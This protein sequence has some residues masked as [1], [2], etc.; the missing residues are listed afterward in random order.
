MSTLVANGFRSLETAPAIKALSHAMTH[1]HE[2]VLL[3]LEENLAQPGRAGTEG[4]RI[5]ACLRAMTSAPILAILPH[6]DEPAQAAV[7]DAGAND[8]V[9]R[10]FD[11][12]N[13]LAR[14]RVWLRQVAR[15]KS[16]RTPTEWPRGRVRF[17]N[18]RRELLVDDRAVHITPIERKLVLALVRNPG[19]AMTEGQAMAAVW[20]ERAQPQARYLRTL[21]RQLRL[22][23]ERDPL[24]PEHLMNMAEGGYRLNLG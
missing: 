3:D 14:I 22:K 23:I 10:P 21:V 2:L 1:A 11:T 4:V 13:L 16:A 24:R 7:L 20:G 18:E 5:A 15:L 12:A 6:P 9:V 17:D 19:E 8:F